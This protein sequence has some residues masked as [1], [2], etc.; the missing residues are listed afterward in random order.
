MFSP[1]LCFKIFPGHFRYVISV[2]HA[3]VYRVLQPQDITSYRKHRTESHGILTKLLAPDDCH[4]PLL[5]I[6]FNE[7]PKVTRKCCVNYNTSLNY[8]TKDTSKSQLCTK[9]NH[10]VSHRPEQKLGN[11]QISIS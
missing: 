4:I 1:I 2:Q 6:T 10:T 8:I 5:Q 9:L 7:M 3:K 11:L